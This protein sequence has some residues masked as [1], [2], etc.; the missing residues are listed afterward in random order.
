MSKCGGLLKFA[1]FHLPADVPLV[2]PRWAAR[3]LHRERALRPWRALALI[4][5]A[6]ALGSNIAALTT[7]SWRLV[8]R[9][10]LI[11]DYYGQVVF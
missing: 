10:R 6:L 9:M 2:P 4:L 3:Y 8:G 11:N 7:D 1:R 5:G